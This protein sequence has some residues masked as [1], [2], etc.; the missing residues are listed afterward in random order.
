MNHQIKIKHG[1][2]R[3]SHCFDNGVSC[4]TSPAEI[5]ICRMCTS[6]LDVQ[7]GT[8]VMTIEGNVIC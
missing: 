4:L 6:L 2:C 7:Y 5:Q 3:L 1:R 8:P